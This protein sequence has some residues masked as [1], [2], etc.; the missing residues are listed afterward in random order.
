MQNKMQISDP[1]AIGLRS[2]IMGF[3]AVLTVALLFSCTKNVADVPDQAAEEATAVDGNPNGNNDNIIHAVPFETTVFVP[4]A[5]GG[6]GE[7]VKLTGFTNFIY[8]TTWTDHGFT[9][10]Y[11]DN[12]HQVKGVGLTSG[13]SFVASGGTNGTALGV[14]YSSQWVATTMRQM[15]I[16]G[17][18]TRFTV[19][20]KYHIAVTADGNISV[21]STEQTADCK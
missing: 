14:W 19:S 9:V 2:M 20:Y 12:V 4:C 18:N 17:Q 7:N 21:S 1:I 15:N 11:H 3:L 10:L 16:I 6:A 8:G 5:N 13:E